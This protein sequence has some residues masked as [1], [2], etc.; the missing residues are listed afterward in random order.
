MQ[1][2]TTGLNNM[3][4]HIPVQQY[5]TALDNRPTTPPQVSSRPAL[6]WKG[7]KTDHRSQ[8]SSVLGLSKS[9]S[10]YQ[11]LSKQKQVDH[12]KSGKDDTMHYIY[13]LTFF[14]TNSKV[15]HQNDFWFRVSYIS[16]NIRRTSIGEN[17][18][19]EW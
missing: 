6:S 19:G 13:R 2:T 17:C 5:M 4:V 10:S 9:Q 12:P 1:N 8:S 3:P 14:S 16:S 18:K 7:R 15:L 11:T